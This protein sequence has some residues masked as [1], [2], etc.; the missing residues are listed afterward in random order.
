MRALGRNSAMDEQE[1]IAAAQ[2]ELARPGGGSRLVR[3][4]KQER[5]E[6]TERII[7]MGTT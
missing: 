4:S 3:L 5:Q 1:L 7:A 6:L 2:E